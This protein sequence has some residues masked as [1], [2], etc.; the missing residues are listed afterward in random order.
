MS[1]SARSPV[2]PSSCSVQ[3]RLCMPSSEGYVSISTSVLTVV[4][5]SGCFVTRRT[6]SMSDS[7]VV[8]VCVIPPRVR[9]ST[10]RLLL[11]VTARSSLRGINRPFSILA[12]IPCIEV[13]NKNTVTAAVNVEFPSRREFEFPHALRAY[14]VQNFFEVQ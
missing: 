5:N 1:Y 12:Q 10:T 14:R 6:L 9:N 13:A 11:T 2:T 8:R 7:G 3:H 4:V